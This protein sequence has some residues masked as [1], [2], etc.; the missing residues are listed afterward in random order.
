[1]EE[2]RI[3]KEKKNEAANWRM[4]GSFADLAASIYK[5]NPSVTLT[6][7]FVASSTPQLSATT[8]GITKTRKNRHERSEIIQIRRYWN[9][10]SCVWEIVLSKLFWKASALS[11]PFFQHCLHERVYKIKEID[12]YWNSTSF[13]NTKISL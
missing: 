13:S 5:N 7:I 8:I 6:S 1:M 3:W 2:W 11:Q 9:R 10:D 12:T 4:Q